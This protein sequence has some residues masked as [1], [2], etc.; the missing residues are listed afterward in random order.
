MTFLDGDQDLDI[1][2]SN[3]VIGM[4]YSF[5]ENITFF[6]FLSIL[7]MDIFLFQTLIIKISN[8][9]NFVE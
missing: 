5:L 9:Y 6:N 1:K 2:T 3:I 4:S 7:G 8:F